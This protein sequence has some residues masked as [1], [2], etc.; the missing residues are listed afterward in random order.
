MAGI[1]EAISSATSAAMPST[2]SLPPAAQDEVSAAISQ[3]FGAYAQEYQAIS[4][5]AA[6]F[7]QQFVEAINAGGGQYAAAE[8]ANTSPL[9]SLFGTILDDI[10]S[11]NQGVRAIIGRLPGALLPQLLSV[12]LPPPLPPP[13]PLPLPLPASLP[14]LVPLPP[15]LPPLLPL[16]PLPPSLPLLPP[17]PLPV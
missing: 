6:L 16:P 5:Q 10:S 9:Q 12:P 4:A 17:P 14:V 7:H 1:G 15:P 11:I 3:L 13:S 2:T 8:A